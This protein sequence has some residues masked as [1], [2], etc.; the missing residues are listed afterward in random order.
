MT[1]IEAKQLATYVNAI[2]TGNLEFH[3]EMLSLFIYTGVLGDSGIVTVV[4]GLFWQLQ[5]YRDSLVM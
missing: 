1:K 5:L 3:M 2:T 4:F